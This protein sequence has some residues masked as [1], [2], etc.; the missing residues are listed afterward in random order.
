M[1]IDKKR[2]FI[3]NTEE[4]IEQPTEYGLFGD[5]NVSGGYFDTNKQ[6]KVVLVKFDNYYV[7]VKY[8]T[9][10]LS[11]LDVWTNVN[12]KGLKKADNRFFAVEMDDKVK[13]IVKDLAPVYKTEG[14]VSLKDLQERQ[15]D[16]ENINII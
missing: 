6:E 7:P 2:V 9:N 12:K 10:T 5:S 11:Y 13:N 16:S 15:Q 8:L 4:I 1:K 3:G 14:K